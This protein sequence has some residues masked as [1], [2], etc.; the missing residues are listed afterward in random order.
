MPPS[1]R[2]PA[3]HRAGKS[4]PVLRRFNHTPPIDADL[5]FRSDGRQTEYADPGLSIDDQNLF[6]AR[7]RCYARLRVVPEEA[8]QPRA[9]W[10]ARR[11]SVDQHTPGALNDKK[12]QC[13]P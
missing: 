7:S 1:P 11:R 3:R 13:S 6:L 2:M 4:I 9:Y 10:N 5:I 12:N 8:I